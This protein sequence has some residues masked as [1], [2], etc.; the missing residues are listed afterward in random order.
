[1][2][3]PARVVILILMAG[4]TFGAGCSSYIAP[5]VTIAD[6]RVTDRTDEGIAVAFTLDAANANDEA[7]P[8][9][10][11]TYSLE[12][13][14]Q[15]VFQGERSPE[16]TLRRF[17]TQQFVLPAGIP[18][19]SVPG[20]GTVHFRLIGSME[21]ITPG[22]FAEVLFDTKVRRPDVSFVQEGTIDLSAAPSPPP[23][24]LP[25]LPGPTNEGEKGQ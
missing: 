16:A 22:A 5:S 4:L 7:L 23:S 8:L 19:A 1:M 21:Y 11:T 10:Q 15:R 24:S 9:R 18:L 25:P 2:N 20:T 6:A 3:T 13:E 14:G 12:L 17:G